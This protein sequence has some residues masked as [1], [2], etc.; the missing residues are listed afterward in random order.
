MG[1]AKFFLMGET[2]NC[3]WESIMYQLYFS[4]SKDYKLVKVRS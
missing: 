3:W 4:G 2:R 1:D